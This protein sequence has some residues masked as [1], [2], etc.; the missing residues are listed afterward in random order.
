M[1]HPV[2]SASSLEDE[3]GDP[4]QGSLTGLSLTDA[5]E[6]ETVESKSSR[7]NPF[8]VFLSPASKPIQDDGGGFNPFAH[9]FKTGA[10]E[11]DPVQSIEDLKRIVIPQQLAEL[12]RSRRF[13]LNET[14]ALYIQGRQF[15]KKWRISEEGFLNWKVLLSGWAKFPAVMLLKSVGPRAV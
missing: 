1:P 6:T 15:Q 8:E 3:S 13:T 5:R 9:Y 12:Q 7:F 14:D 10:G 2:D 11:R 4:L